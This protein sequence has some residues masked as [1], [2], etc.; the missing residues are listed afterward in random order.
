MATYK[1][2]QHPQGK[3]YVLGLAGNFWMPVSNAFDR[4]IDAEKWMKIQITKVD[5]NA[6]KLAY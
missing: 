4:K 3:F 6:K 2:K 5:P 1:V